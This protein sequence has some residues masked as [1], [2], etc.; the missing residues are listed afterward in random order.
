MQSNDFFGEMNLTG[1]ANSLELM[2]KRDYPF[3]GG[4]CETALH[5][6]AERGFSELCVVLVNDGADL[7]AKDCFGE[8][9][10][11]WAVRFGRDETAH[12]LKA[13]EEN[14]CLALSIAQQGKESRRGRI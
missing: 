14:A 5:R 11:D 2:L 10:Y 12:V 4:M 9:A 6:A 8:T 1:I 3:S 13:M 7:M